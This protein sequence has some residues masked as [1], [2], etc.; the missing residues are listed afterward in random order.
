MNVMPSLPFEPDDEGSV[1]VR[2]LFLSDIHLGARGCQAERLLDF[3]RHYDADTIFLVGDIVDG[4][5]LKSGLV[6]AAS[7]QRRRSEAPAQGPQGRADRLRSG[8]P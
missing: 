2:A 5:A 4:W 1:R 3:L 8:Q 7:P 6:L